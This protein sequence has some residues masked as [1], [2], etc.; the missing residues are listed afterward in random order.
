[1]ACSTPPMYWSIGNQYAAFALSNGALIVVRIG[2]A[3]E[4]PGRIDE[5]VHRVRLAP[6]RTAAFR[7][8]RVHEF[9]HAR[10]RRLPLPGQRHILR[11]AHRQLIIRHRNNSILLAINHRNR[12]APISLARNAPIFQPVCGFAPSPNPSPAASSAIFSIACSEVSSVYGPES[13]SRPYSVD[14]SLIRS[15]RSGPPCS[16]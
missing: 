16:G 7:A 12:R 10:Q 6:R 14:A 13:T 8:S 2:V 11:Q 3:I 4:I 5:R 1:M 9:R 15:A